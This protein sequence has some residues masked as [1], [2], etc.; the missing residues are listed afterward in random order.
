MASNRFISLAVGASLSIA[1]CL[2]V[3]YTY[4]K[5]KSL[6]RHPSSLLF[7]R[8][9]FDLIFAVAFIEVLLPSIDCSST[10]GVIVTFLTQM[11]GL[12]SEIWYLLMSVDLLLSIT[13]PFTNYKS[14]RRLYTASAFLISALSGFILVTSPNGAGR[15][16]LGVCWTRNVQGEFNPYNWS[17]FFAPLFLIYLFCLWLLVFVRRQ[18]KGGLAATYESRQEVI[19]NGRR[20][21]IAFTVYWIIAGIMYG[22]L[23][24]L[25]DSDRATA[26]SDTT[27]ALF[28]AVSFVIGAK[29]MVTMAVWMANYDIKAAVRLHNASKRSDTLLELDLDL[30]PHLNK[31]LRGEIMMFVQSG[32]LRSVA[33]SSKATGETGEVYNITMTR[34]AGVELSDR[35]KSKD[36]A[37]KR[38]AS[39]ESKEDAGDEEAK[40]DDV[41]LEVDDDDSSTVAGAG[42]HMEEGTA[43][44]GVGE[45]FYFRDYEPSVFAK[46]RAAFKISE[47]DYIRSMS[48]L[49]VPK[50]SE[51]ASG[52]FFVFTKDQRFAVKTMSKDECIFL[53]EMAGR[54]LAYMSKHPNTLITKYFGLHS[55][56]MYRQRIYFVVMENVFPPKEKLTIHE[57]YD[58]KGSWIS[59][60]ADRSKGDNVVLKD[61]DLNLRLQINPELSR[62]LGREMRSDVD[63]L[64]SN[65]IMD[66]SLLLGVHRRRFHIDGDGP[67]RRVSRGGRK[68]QAKR[69]GS[70]AASDEVGADGVPFYR[71]SQGGVMALVVEGPGTYFFGIIDC[72]QQWDWKK[73]AEAAAKRWL[74][75]K[76]PHGISAVPPE[77]YAV[78][79]KQRVIASFIERAAREEEEEG[80]VVEEE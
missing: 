14:N 9:I 55:I 23:Y 21:V 50:F 72:L 31:A 56:K 66:Y 33:H 12:G 19:V 16:V 6:R 38:K 64:S 73:K 30:Q 68:R 65:G 76:D 2:V 79:F 36:E 58:L 54:Y 57:R 48:S 34:D 52:A 67:S 22:I 49:S 47:D 62:R 35:T 17:L 20:S 59:R 43:S 7:Y 78:R 53:R 26:S 28:V 77:E 70:R 46:L 24:F 40:G 75:F 29:G 69:R 60:N 80:L 25:G 61:G 74:K 18:L 27:E 1:S 63:F 42:V 45:S 3:I 11:T 32:I 10:L 71:E 37:P 15:S 39:E 4:I 13:N 41:A 44:G 8:A 5:Y 51:G